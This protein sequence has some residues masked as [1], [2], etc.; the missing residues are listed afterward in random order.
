MVL[1]RTV[2]RI[3]GESKVESQVGAFTRFKLTLPLA[4]AITQGL[5]FKIGGQST[6]CPRPT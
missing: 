1:W 6:P 3:S 4:G 5:L 2:A